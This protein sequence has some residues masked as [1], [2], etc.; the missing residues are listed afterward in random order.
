VHNLY[1]GLNKA[2]RCALRHR[3]ITQNP[4]DA[5]EL[6]KTGRSEDFT[7]MFLRST[8]VERIAAELDAWP[9]YGLLVRLAAQTGL[10]AAELAGLRVRDL[11]LR[12][13]H[14]EVRQTIRCVNGFWTV[15]MSKSA[16]STRN[17][18][19]LPRS[20]IADLRE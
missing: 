6:P 12:A 9:P 14:V 1:V 8:E 16:R 13:G 15:G 17:V 18:P 7:P 19:L 4:C 2:F 11:S 3:L 10:R 5:V 20:L